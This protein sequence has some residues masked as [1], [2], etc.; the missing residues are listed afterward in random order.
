MSRLY[1][2]LQGCRG[3]ATRCGSTTSGLRVSAQS[4]NGSLITYMNI[5]DN[6]ET[7][8]K[9]KYSDDS[10][11]CGDEIIFEGTLEELKEKLKG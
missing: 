3:E 1:G 2:T 11:S 6:G 10:S 7:V 9:L 5:N 8:V 4:Y